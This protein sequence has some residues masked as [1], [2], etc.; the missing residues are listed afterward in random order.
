VKTIAEALATVY[1][2]QS[3][4]PNYQQALSELIDHQGRYNEVVAEAFATTEFT[5]LLELWCQLPFK[6]NLRDVIVSVF[7][8]GLIVGIEYTKT[9]EIAT[10][11]EPPTV[12][13]PLIYRQVRKAF[14]QIAAMGPAA[15]L[16][17]MESLVL[18]ALS[19]E[20]NDGR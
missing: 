17:E 16:A 15:T 2:K 5:E 18:Q 11:P 12:V 10:A 4:T 8:A 14:D 19:G 20:V 1:R 3:V 7:S 6:L 9:N 13:T